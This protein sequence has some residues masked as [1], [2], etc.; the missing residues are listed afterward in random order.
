[1]LTNSITGDKYVGQTTQSLEKRIY[2]HVNEK[3]NRHISNAIRKYG[4]ENFKIEVLCSCFDKE[5]LNSAEVYFVQKMECLFP[6]GYN[7]RAGGEQN[8]ICSVELKQKISIAKIGKP[9][10]KRRGETRS[11]EYRQKISA[12]LGGHKIKATNLDTKEIKIYDTAHST[13]IDGHNP[14]NVVSICRGYGRR[15]HS[16]RWT[17]QYLQANQSGSSKSNIIEHAQRLESEPALS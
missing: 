9:N 12:G 3:R 11:S 4:I 1:M 2:S 5:S 7:H 10:F 14:S 17:F 16:K 6:T 13:K 15:Y 8:G